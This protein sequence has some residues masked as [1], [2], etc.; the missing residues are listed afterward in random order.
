MKKSKVFQSFKVWQDNENLRQDMPMYVR[1]GLK[2]DEIINFRNRDYSNFK[3]SIRTLDRRLRYFEI[4]YNHIETP[5]DAV[6]EAAQKELSGPGKLLGDRAMHKKI[7]QEYN[8]FVSR[9]AVYNLLYELDAEGL[10]SCGDVGKNKDER[11][12]HLRLKVRIGCTHWADM[13]SSWAFKINFSIRCVWLCRYV[14]PKNPMA[15]HLSDQFKSK[16]HWQMVPGTSNGN[17]CNSQYDQ[18]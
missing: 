14:K 5:V 10:E 18:A 12:V 4:Y 15:P 16:Y 1:Q 3:W 6:R 7:R 13:I 17:P 8:L 9:D 11:K 2:R